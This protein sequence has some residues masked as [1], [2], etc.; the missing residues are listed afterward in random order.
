LE[1]DIFRDYELDL[2]SF[3]MRPFDDGRFVVIV[4]GETLYDKER[5]GKFPKYA[6]DIKEQ[7]SIYT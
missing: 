2:A 7:L 6:D 4:N 3:T 1:A 5:T